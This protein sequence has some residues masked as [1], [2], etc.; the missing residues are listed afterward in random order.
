MDHVLIVSA[1]PDDLIACCGLA[2]L[3]KNKVAFHLIDFTGGERGLL[4]DGISM[5]ETAAIRRKEEERACALLDINP[6]F[7]GEI[8]GEAFA[9]RQSCE[10]LSAVIS[11]LNPVA[12]MTHWPLDVHPDHVITAAATLKALQMAALQP[13]VLLFEAPFQSKGF[14]PDFHVDI[15][16]VFASKLEL[17]RCYECQ[18]R[19]D[20]L[21]ES[22]TW[23]ARFRGSRCRCRYAE[24]YSHY[25]PERPGFVSVLAEYCRNPRG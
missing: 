25:F 6:R 11:S 14:L 23:D 22:Q 24:S 5:E 19:N 12:I 18:N 3:L 17:I 7:L 21:V 13:E 15:S 2:F 8:D 20:E 9:G 16:T 4:S 10:K 1:H